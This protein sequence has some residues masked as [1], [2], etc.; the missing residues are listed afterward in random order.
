MALTLGAKVWGGAMFCGNPQARGTG[1][2]YGD[3]VRSESAASNHEDGRS[4]DRIRSPAENALGMPVL[5]RLDQEVP[6]DPQRSL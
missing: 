4:I 1:L 5:S 6:R 2:P 3:A